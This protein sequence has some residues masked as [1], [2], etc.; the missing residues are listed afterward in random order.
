MEPSLYM[1][2]R[3]SKLTKNSILVFS[4]YFVNK[5]M[6]QGEYSILFALFNIVP[7]FP[8]FKAGLKAIIRY[9]RKTLKSK[10]LDSCLSSALHSMASW[11]RVNYELKTRKIT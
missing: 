1:P 6:R 7:W 3:C 5:Y 4:I 8:Y 9:S 10:A 2:I 11:M